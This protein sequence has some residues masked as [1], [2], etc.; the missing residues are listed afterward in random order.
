M[1][2]W[3]RI[4]YPVTIASLIVPATCA[5][6]RSKATRAPVVAVIQGIA[7]SVL[8][9]AWLGA[10]RETRE[11][12]LT[13]FE[14]GRFA[15]CEARCIGGS[16]EARGRAGRKFALQLDPEG[17]V[18]LAAAMVESIEDEVHFQYAVLAQA[19]VA[20]DE[21]RRERIVLKIS[22]DGARAVVRGRAVHHSYLL[23]DQVPPPANKPRRS[24][25][26][27][28]LEGALLGAVPEP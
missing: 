26:R 10:V 15:L 4:I 19:S 8:P 28:R 13:L 5:S 9:V 7:S 27:M 16:W 6:A 12:S 2:N 1:R 14:D 18:A 24:R 23:G 3:R 11:A 21:R 22:R 20:L 17:R 25:Y